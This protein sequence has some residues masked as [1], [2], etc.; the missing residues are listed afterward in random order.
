MIKSQREASEQITDIEE[1]GNGL[2][3]WEDQFIDS[4]SRQEKLTFKQREIID[5]IH[6]EKVKYHGKST[7]KDCRIPR[8]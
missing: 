5:R 4:V 3:D 8:T 7:Q 2:S 6:T 1:R